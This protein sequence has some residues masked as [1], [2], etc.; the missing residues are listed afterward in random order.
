MAEPWCEWSQL[1]Q[2]ACA[3][4]RKDRRVV[5]AVL[6]DFGALA[7]TAGDRDT[8]PAIEA[9]Y[10]GTCRGCGERWEPGDMITYSEG[11]D[12]W[13]CVQCAGA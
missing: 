5:T 8:G 2:A 11:E 12:G 9:L 13:V 7:E 1:P 10:Y 4:C 6:P 3:H